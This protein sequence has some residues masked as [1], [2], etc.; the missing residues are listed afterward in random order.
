V[1]VLPDALNSASRPSEAVPA[2]FTVTEL[3]TA[4][5]IWEAT[6][7]FQISSYSLNWSPVRPVS[8]G[9]RKRSPEGRIASCA[10]CAFLTFPAY[11]R[12]WAGR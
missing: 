3:P 11:V 8:A 9:V 10:S 12:G 4:S 7:R 1:I 5:F 2:I 6:V